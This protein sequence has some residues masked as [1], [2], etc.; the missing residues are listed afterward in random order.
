M[1]LLGL[2][3][4]LVVVVGLV[5]LAGLAVVGLAVGVSLGGMRGGYSKPSRLWFWRR[6][7]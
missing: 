1:S 6:G 7:A 3:I 4:G 5:L 2:G